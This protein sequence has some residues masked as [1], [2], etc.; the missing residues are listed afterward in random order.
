MALGMLAHGLCALVGLSNA[1]SNGAEVL[2]E[3][4]AKEK[5]TNRPITCENRGCIALDA[6][7][8]LRETLEDTRD[9]T[10]EQCRKGAS[11]GGRKRIHRR[12]Q[13]KCRGSLMRRQNREQA[14]S[15]PIGS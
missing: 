10:E 9:K 14:S 5:P 8:A 13:M 6:Q 4:E 7:K 1:L 2:F 12:P 3:V 15:K 11:H